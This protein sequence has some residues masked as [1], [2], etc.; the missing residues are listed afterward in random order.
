[1]REGRSRIARFL[2]RRCRVCGL[3]LLLLVVFVVDASRA[4]E[5]QWTTSL[6]IGA[7]HVHQ[8]AIAPRLASAGFKCRFTPSCSHYAEEVLRRHGIVGG[9]WRTL[10]RIARCGPWTPMG[11]VDPPN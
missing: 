8:R 6:A 9:G 10:V 2:G 5:R 7:I 3:L 1:M 11:M 4:P